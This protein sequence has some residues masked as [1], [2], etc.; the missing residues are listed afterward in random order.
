MYNPYVTKQMENMK[1]NNYTGRILL[2]IFSTKDESL[3]PSIGTINKFWTKNLDNLALNSFF[4]VV[5]QE[6]LS[7]LSQLY[8]DDLFKKYVSVMTAN[9]NADGMNTELEALLGKAIG[10]IMYHAGDVK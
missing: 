8:R 4:E 2:E 10:Y 9:L 5:T 7:A 3:M 6:D 1:L